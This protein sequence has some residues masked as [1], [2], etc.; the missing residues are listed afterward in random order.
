MQRAP[1]PVL[2]EVVMKLSDASLLLLV[3]FTIILQLSRE[4]RNKYIKQGIVMLSCLVSTTASQA[5]YD[6]ATDRNYF[7]VM[8]FAIA[9]VVNTASLIKIVGIPIPNSSMRLKD[10]LVTSLLVVILILPLRKTTFALFACDISTII[11]SVVVYCIAAIAEEVAFRVSFVN[12]FLAGDRLTTIADKGPNALEFLS[13]AGIS[14]I[15]AFAHFEFSLKILY[16]RVFYSV[17]SIFILV[18]TRRAS[19]LVIIHFINNIL[20]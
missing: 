10:Y 19:V 2:L 15:F 7:L 12:N 4:Y 3:V 18:I 6:L 9:I 5:F 20:T 13:I 16:T 17:A 11:V 8:L 14:L 1:A